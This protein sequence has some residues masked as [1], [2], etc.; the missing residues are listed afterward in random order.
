MVFL[1]PSV[2]LYLF[3]GRDDNYGAKESDL[4][5]GELE[6]VDPLRE[7]ED[8]VHQRLGIAR[9]HLVDGVLA[10]DVAVEAD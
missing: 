1:G 9:R 2:S 5:I 7:V 3:T 4:C 8:G 10:Y 6:P